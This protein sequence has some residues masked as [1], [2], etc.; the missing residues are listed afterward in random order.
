VILLYGFGPDQAFN[1]ASAIIQEDEG[2]QNSRKNT[3]QQRDSFGSFNT[4]YRVY[5]GWPT[6]EHYNSGFIGIGKKLDKLK[7]YLQPLFKILEDARLK[8]MLE[9]KTSFLGFLGEVRKDI[10]RF[11]G[12]LG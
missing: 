10:V 8:K 12:F 5:I 3:F 2:E 11:L 6:L 9:V 4:L 1:L 7:I